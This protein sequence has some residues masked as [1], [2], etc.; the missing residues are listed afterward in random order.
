[1]RHNVWSIFLQ[2]LSGVLREDS[3]SCNNVILVDCSADI[4]YGGRVKRCI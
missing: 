2:M 1:M 4:E 3:S